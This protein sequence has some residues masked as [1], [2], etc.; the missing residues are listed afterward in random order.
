MIDYYLRFTSEEEAFTAL[1]EAGYVTKDLQGNEIIAIATHEYA[2]DQIGVIYRGGQWGFNENGPY[3]IEEPIKL[4]GWHINIRMVSGDI[5][6]NLLSF[7][8]PTPQS[9]YRVFA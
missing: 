5:A 8:I 3:T 2:V 1:K 4:D 9:P 6:E 7:V